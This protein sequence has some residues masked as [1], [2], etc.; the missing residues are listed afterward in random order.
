MQVNTWFVSLYIV[1]T[2]KCILNEIYKPTKL[3][4]YQVFL[5]LANKNQIQIFRIR[6]YQFLLLFCRN[7]FSLLNI[8][9]NYFGNYY[10]QRR[11]VKFKD[12]VPNHQ[13]YIFLFKDFVFKNNFSLLLCSA[14]IFNIIHYF[15]GYCYITQR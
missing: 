10:R 1:N 14:R 12:Y 13:I 7:S 6:F 8:F 4:K 5:L 9:Y 11:I 2:V 3:M 15:F